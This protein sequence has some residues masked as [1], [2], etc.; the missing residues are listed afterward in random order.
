MFELACRY[1]YHATKAAI[2][3]LVMAVVA[4]SHHAE[5]DRTRFAELVALAEVAPIREPMALR[6]GA[7]RTRLSELLA[8]ADQDT[9][10]TRP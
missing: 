5:V 7:D 4:Y 2:V 1:T 3:I 10:E 9:S 6:P 8:A